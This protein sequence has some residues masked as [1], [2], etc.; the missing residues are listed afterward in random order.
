LLPF[1]DTI[2]NMAEALDLKLDEVRFTAEHGTAAH[3]V[4]LGWIKIPRNCIAAVRATW[5]G[6]CAGRERL[7]TSIAWRL[8]DDLNGAW[9]QQ[10]EHYVL[11]LD[12]HP[13]L[14]ARLQWVPPAEW[15]PSDYSI[16]TALPA[17]NAIV[18]VNACR[19]GL[20]TL[21]DVG[22]PYSPVGL[23]K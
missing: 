13:N 1:A 18:P 5:S 14:I 3:D 7:A 10:A 19:P 15:H 22:L 12:S 2:T 23:W 17:V 16:L 4:D 8:T 9:P 11:Q 21:R 20:L 6:I